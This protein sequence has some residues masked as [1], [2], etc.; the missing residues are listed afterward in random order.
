MI[1]SIYG[2][3]KKICGNASSKGSGI[4][5]IPQCYKNEVDWI[6]TV[7]YD[8][9]GDQDTLYLCD[10]CARRLEEDVKKHG[11]DIEKERY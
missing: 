4:S 8:E 10:E 5:G 11:Y 3:D 7:Y 9:H 1:R 6:I 2:K